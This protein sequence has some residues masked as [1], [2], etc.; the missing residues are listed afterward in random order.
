MFNIVLTRCRSVFKPMPERVIRVGNVYMYQIGE[1]VEIGI[2]K[3]PRALFAFVDP[4]K[5]LMG[6]LEATYVLTRCV[7]DSD[8]TCADEVVDEEAVIAVLEKVATTLD[9]VITAGGRYSHSTW[10]EYV[11]L[12]RSAYEHIVAAIEKL[13]MAKNVTPTSVD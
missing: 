12:L 1:K 7:Y 3:E 6:V 10:P 8:G 9:D 4:A 5:L 13:R 11:D 2:V